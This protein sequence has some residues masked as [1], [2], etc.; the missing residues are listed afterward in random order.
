MYANVLLN[1]LNELREKI[2][3]EALLSILSIS[4]NEFNKFNNTGCDKLFAII[5]LSE[6]LGSF[7]PSH[8][9]MVLFI[10]HKL[11]FQTR[12]HCH[13]VGLDVWF[14]VE[15]VVYFHT[16]CVRTVKALVRLGLHE[17]SLVVCLISTIIS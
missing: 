10:C 17:P 16:S 13:P 4:P 14:L 6:N 1:L 15:P 11:I 12:M 7:E 5:C 3:F 8:E 9:I 2:S